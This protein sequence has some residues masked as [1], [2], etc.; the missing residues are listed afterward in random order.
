M[1]EFSGWLKA[2]RPEIS[3]RVIGCVTVDPH[4]TTENELLARARE[5]LAEAGGNPE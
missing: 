4:H 3:A 2:N 1:A 5:F